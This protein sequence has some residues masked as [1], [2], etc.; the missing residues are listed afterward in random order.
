MAV[1]LT[2][3]SAGLAQIQAESRLV[4]NTVSNSIRLNIG[5]KAPEPAVRVLDE[6]GR[7]VA[8]ATV[9]F[10]VISD[11]AGPSATFPGGARS[12]GATSDASGAAAAPGLH[13]NQVTGRYR[14]EIQAQ[15]PPMLPPEAPVSI[16]AENVLDIQRL[17]MTPGEAFVNNLC[18]NT[19]G[20][21]KVQVRD[22]AGKPVI[23]A[24]VTF[25]LPATGAS[26][27]FTGGSATKTVTTDDTGQA[28]VKSFVP[29]KTKGDFEVEAVASLVN[30]RANAVIAGSNMKQGC[31]PALL[32]V[33]GAGGAAGAAA[34]L[35]SRK[36]SSTTT[37]PPTTPVST[38]SI[39][40]GGDPRFG[41]GH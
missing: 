15:K 8:E 3:P 19:V 13:P 25:R 14:I 10:T 30:L 34:A 32:V 24:D 2:L 28:A 41:G 37:T 22:E 31:F 26:G 4:V 17:V 1:L 20:E 12:L 6:N 29:N 7:P 38:I 9:T 21:P 27:V 33:L 35:A 36:G 5:S 39:V 23:G 11:A 16:A 18:K 40:S